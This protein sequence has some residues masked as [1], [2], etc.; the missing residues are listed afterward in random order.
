M[1]AAL[2]AKYTGAGDRRYL[3]DADPDFDV[4]YALRPQSAMMWCLADVRRIA[5]FE[6]EIAYRGMLVSWTPR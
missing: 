2:T 6:P 5:Q 4:V 3:P 1:V